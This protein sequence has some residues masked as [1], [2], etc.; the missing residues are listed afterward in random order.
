MPNGTRIS[1]VVEGIIDES[2]IRKLIAHVGAI[3]GPVYGKQGKNF[4]QQKIPGYN[5]AA[6]FAP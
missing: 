3:P 4:V 5:N 1:A 2:V 6:R